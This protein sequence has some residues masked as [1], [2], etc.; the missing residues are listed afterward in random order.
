MKAP[1]SLIDLHVELL[2]NGHLELIMILITLS[3]LF[4]DLS[5]FNPADFL[6]DEKTR[7]N[8]QKLYNMPAYKEIILKELPRIF[9]SGCV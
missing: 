7:K 8:L 4:M 5:T 3:V 6:D 2:K 1:P 9:Y